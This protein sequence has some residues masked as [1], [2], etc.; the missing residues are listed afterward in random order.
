M[1]INLFKQNLYSTFVLRAQGAHYCELMLFHQKI[2]Y[3]SHAKLK[4]NKKKTSKIGKKEQ[5]KST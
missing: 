2:N 4:Q 5:K 1:V 3:S